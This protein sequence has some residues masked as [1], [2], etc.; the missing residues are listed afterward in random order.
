[1]NRPV[2]GCSIEYGVMSVEVSKDQVLNSI[3]PQGICVGVCGFLVFLSL[4]TSRKMNLRTFQPL[5]TST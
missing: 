4:F 3:R 1:M 5:Y 2:L